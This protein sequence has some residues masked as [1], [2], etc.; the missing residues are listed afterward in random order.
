MLSVCEEGKERKESSRT[1]RFEPVAKRA[2]EPRLE[3]A[4]LRRETKV[5]SADYG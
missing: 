5:V 2:V 3:I 1:Q 4:T